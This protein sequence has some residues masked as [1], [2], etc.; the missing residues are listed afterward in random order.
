MSKKQSKEAQDECTC[1]FNNL[2]DY[3]VDRVN[4]Q[5]EDIAS[6]LEDLRS[7]LDVKNVYSLKTS[8]NIMAGVFDGIDEFLEGL[9]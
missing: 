8:M 5:S 7:K 4:Q 2:F 3:F 1:D 9:R 6:R